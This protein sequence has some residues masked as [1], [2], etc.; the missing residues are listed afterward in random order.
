MAAN[1]VESLEKSFSK[2]KESEEV[3]LACLLDPRSKK[4]P[5]FFFLPDIL[6][7]AKAWLREE[8]TPSDTREAET[9]SDEGDPKEAKRR[10]PDPQ[11]SR[12]SV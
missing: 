3:A 1:L 12:Q 7:Q 8:A 10:G 5:F 2:M 4:Q 6:T 9:A 11:S